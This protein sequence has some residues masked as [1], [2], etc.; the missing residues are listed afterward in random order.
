MKIEQRF[1]ILMIFMGIALC[2]L[3]FQNC[4]NRFASM[5][6]ES[7][8][9]SAV[10]PT[11]NDPL[12]KKIEIENDILGPTENSSFYSYDG[13]IL[14]NEK[15]L[16]I[17]SVFDENDFDNTHGAVSHTYGLI[18]HAG[19]SDNKKFPTDFIDIKFGQCAQLISETGAPLNC[20]ERPY[21]FK[22]KKLVK[23][24]KFKYMPCVVDCQE[25]IENSTFWIFSSGKLV[26]Y[27]SDSN[28][29]QSSG[30][31]AIEVELPEAGTEFEIK[32]K[33]NR[34]LRIDDL[35][36]VS[37]TDET[38][39]FDFEDQFGALTTDG[40]MIERSHHPRTDLAGRVLKFDGITLQSQLF[41]FQVWG[42]E[43]QGEENVIASVNYAFDQIGLWIYNSEDSPQW[44]SVWVVPPHEPTFKFDQPITR[45]SFDYFRNSQ[46]EYSVFADG[47][48]L[49]RISFS[50][51]DSMIQKITL[52]FPQ[53]VMSVDIQ[54]YLSNNNVFR[55]GNI[56][57]TAQNPWP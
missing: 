40:Q 44:G 6:P 56:E 10:N 57:L 1:T 53:P 55:I 38:T 17:K 2:G 22:F 13:R 29:L 30:P 16:I 32:G 47:V 51:N 18:N 11:P 31:V 46:G 24:I 25:S 43:K 48:F 14:F 9:N 8:T 15:G 42:R 19:S 45:M 12:I 36:L 7:A 34:I 3:F 26:K 23:K 49:K 4:S 27:F 5:T 20:Y 37:P 35:E 52:D 50:S 54:L 39:F 28:S 21:L 33:K 41:P